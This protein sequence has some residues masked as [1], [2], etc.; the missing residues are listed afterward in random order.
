MKGIIDNIIAF[1]SIQAKALSIL[2]ANTQKALKESEKERK[3]NEQAER[4]KS[5]V[6]ELTMNLNNMLTKFHFLKERKNRKQEQFTEGQTKAITEFAVFVKSLTGNVSSLLKRFQA[7]SA[8]EEK[9]GKEIK[10]LEVSVRQKLKEFNKAL[11]ETKAA[12]TARLIR[13]VQNIPGG[14]ARLFK[15]RSIIPAV[16]NRRKSDKPPEKPPS[17][18]KENPPKQPQD[19]YDSEL[20]NIVNSSNI[21]S[22]RS[23]EK[24]SKFLMHLKV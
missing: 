13:F 16:A 22:L 8:F 12:L 17:N 7:E 18:M 19:V 5:F 15:G 21:K 23:N 9:I 4:V 10:E 14:L 1:Y 20:E 6:K 3:A 2:I 24:R 11:D